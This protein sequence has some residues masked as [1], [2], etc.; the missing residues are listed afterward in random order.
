MCC[1]HASWVGPCP[2]YFWQHR[3]ESIII[4][5]DFNIFWNCISCNYLFFGLT[6][7]L[8]IFWH[9][10]GRLGCQKMDRDLKIERIRPKEKE[11]DELPHKEMVKSETMRLASGK[12]H[13]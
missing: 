6:L 5:T 2:Q 8:S 4:V 3:S 7:A 1:Y 11:Q 12:L 13:R 9:P 10:Q